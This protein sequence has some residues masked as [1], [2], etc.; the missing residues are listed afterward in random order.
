MPS[1]CL[2]FQVHQPYR[3]NEFSFFDLGKNKNYFNGKLNKKVLDKVSEKCYLPANKLLFDLIQKQDIHFTFSLSGVFLEQLEKYR[4]D[5]LAS[6]QQLVATGNVEL[7]AETYYHSLSFFDSKKEFKNQVQKHNEKLKTLFNYQP[8]H[9]RNT[10][11]LF[12]N[13]VATE[14]YNLGYQA[15]LTE[16]VDRYLKDNNPNNLYHSKEGL[17]ILTRNYKLT[18]DIAFRYSNTKWKHYPLTAQKF[19]KWVADEE[20]EVI[21]LFMDYE[22]IGEHHWKDTGIFDFWTE[23]PQALSDQNIDIISTKKTNQLDPKQLLDIK[24]TISWADTERDLSAW[25]GNDLQKEA[26]KKCYDLREK[27]TSKGGEI[28]KDW[29]KLST[30]DHLYYMSTK[31]Q[32][33]G[34]V[35]NYFSPFNTPYDSYI[36]FMNCIADLELRLGNLKTIPKR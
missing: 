12:N 33:D 7:L 10:E 35:H 8:I 30:S 14:V 19:A 34:A 4:P 22:T 20:G 31:H 6:F 5:V 25:L 13:E 2:Y 11:L 23:L 29:L 3:I 32:N 15:I 18:D 1:V 24:K 16:G 17:K 36:F 27:V 9:F 21:N 26:F 28:L